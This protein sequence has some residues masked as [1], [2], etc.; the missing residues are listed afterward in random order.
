MEK[1]KRGLPH[2]ELLGLF[3]GLEELPQ[4]QRQHR[5]REDKSYD[6]HAARESAAELPD[7]EGRDLGKAALV[8]DG[9]SGPLRAVHFALDGADG[10]K[11]GSA[12]K[13]EDH[14]GKSGELCGPSHRPNEARPPY[15]ECDQCEFL[16][17]ETRFTFEVRP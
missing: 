4:E 5:E 13:V 12:Q 2:S 6:V 10:R 8:A 16:K 1:E 14:E 15:A 9:E 3:V 11:A 7:D 17:C